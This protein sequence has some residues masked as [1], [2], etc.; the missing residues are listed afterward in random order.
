MFNSLNQTQD[1]TPYV[2]LEKRRPQGTENLYGLLHAIKN[3][4]QI[5][6]T[7]QIFWEDDISHR[8][9]EPYGLKE[10]KNRWYLVA[11]DLKDNAIKTFGL[12]RM[13]ALEISHSTFPFP[14]FD[15]DEHYRYCFGI[16]SPN[17][18]EPEMLVLRFNPMQGKYIKTLPLHHTQW[19]IQDNDNALVIG[20]KVFITHDLLMELLSFGKSMEVIAP[21]ALYNEL[22]SEHWFAYKQ[23]AFIQFK[24]E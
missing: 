16:I 5:G 11:N 4:I 17:A 1:M 13:T 19:V 9:V 20:L 2:H 3:R 7:Y 8:R 24:V 21:D 23:K 18:T 15:I 22:R 12:D 6:F 14:A 10:F